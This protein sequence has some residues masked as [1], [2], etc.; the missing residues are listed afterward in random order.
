MPETESNDDQSNLE[1]L[2]AKFDAGLEISEPV[3]IRWMLHAELDAASGRDPHT[4]V[5]NYPD[6]TPARVSWLDERGLLRH[7]PFDGPFPP[8]YPQKLAVHQCQQVLFRLLGTTRHSARDRAYAMLLTAE[9][10]LHCFDAKAGR[11]V[12]SSLVLQRRVASL[13]TYLGA[14]RA[15]M[16]LKLVISILSWPEEK[17]G[18][19]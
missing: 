16:T 19:D 10:G 17:H 13:S 12:N 11:Q 5:V 2:I 7:R 6:G 8:G 3:S 18:L 1:S 15:W 4:L 14:R 9:A